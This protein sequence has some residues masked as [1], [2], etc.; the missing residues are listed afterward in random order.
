MPNIALKDILIGARQEAYRMRHFYVG[1]E[2]LLIAL[3]EIRGSLAG[4]IV[5]QHGLTPEYV[6]D[7]LRRKVG[8]GGKHTLWAGVPNTPRADVIL[9]IAN[10]LALDA[11]REEINERDLLIAL[12]EEANSLTLRVLHAL[13]LDDFDGIA[14]TVRNYQIE[15]DSRQPYIMVDFGPEFQ[16][17]DDIAKDE[18][19]LLR[20][21]FYGYKTIRIERRLTGG[22]SEATLLV[23]TPLHVDNREDAPVV[24][25][26]N[27]VDKIL[28]EAQRYESHVKN[29]LPPMTARLEE[30]PVAPEMSHLAGL[31]YTLVAD[32]DSVPRDMRMILDDWQV[33]D[34][35]DWL[36]EAL[37]KTFGRIWWEQ[38][39]PYRFQA[40]REYDWLLPPIL[41]LEVMESQELPSN[42]HT[43]RVPIKRSKLRRMDFGDPVAVD[44]FIVQQVHQKRGT[45]QLA[46]GH[47][48]EAA[49]AYK[50]ELRGVDLNRT[51]FYRGEVVERIIGTVWQTRGQELFNAVRALEPDFDPQADKIPI[52]D[53]LNLPNPIHAYEGLLDSYVNGTLSTIHGDLHPGNIMV[54]PNKSAFLVDFAHTRDGHT[55]FDWATLETSLLSDF[56]S[57]AAGDTWDD[58]RRTLAKLIEL[59]GGSREWETDDPLERA[60]LLIG[61]VRDMAAHGLAEQDQWAEYHLALMFCGLRTLTWDTVSIAGRRL[62]L[63]VSALAIHELR[64]RF[65]P[66]SSTGTPSPDDTDIS[67]PDI[68]INE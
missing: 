57:Q 26:I 53:G 24:V 36:Y 23:V 33:Q 25:K 58:M 51:T 4:R 6:I 66:S 48:T 17:E 61:R 47:G 32:H 38:N 43:L 60:L 55:V 52:K 67:P 5:Q 65:R 21:M 28:D 2:H 68:G 18:L 7:A 39:R 40:W 27:Q 30:M 42:G 64:T 59:N 13:G 16:R 31:K 19:F 56:V 63:L 45:V 41:T 37:Y 15:P 29:K 8:K 10:D 62:M 3:L 44:N 50:V 14:E 54:G 11:G 34:I 49:K 35:G 9:G 46:V 1:A 20:R 12:F 22:Y